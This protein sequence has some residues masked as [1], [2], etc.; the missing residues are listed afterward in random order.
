M[1][2]YGV[3]LTLVTADLAKG[4]RGGLIFCKAQFNRLWGLEAFLVTVSSAG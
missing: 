4:Y 3:L 2:I 1:G